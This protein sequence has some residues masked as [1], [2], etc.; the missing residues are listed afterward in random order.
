ML[1]AMLPTASVSKPAPHTREPEWQRDRL[2]ES[3]KKFLSHHRGTKCQDQQTEEPEVRSGWAEWINCSFDN[4]LGLM[5]FKSL[6]ATCSACPG[7]LSARFYR[8]RLVDISYILSAES[9]GD[10][11][12]ELT[13]GFGEPKRHFEDKVG[14]LTSAEWDIDDSV[15]TAEV[16]SIHAVVDE[17]TFLRANSGAVH[18]GVRI[19]LSLNGQQNPD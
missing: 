16:V 10:L 9:V 6:S 5:G 3:L 12:P 11:L 7:G 15:L 2:N 4:D 8:K 18:T 14:R 13:K 19:R 17:G 1:L